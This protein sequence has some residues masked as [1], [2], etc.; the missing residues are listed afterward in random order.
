MN[1]PFELPSELSIYTADSTRQA[2]LAWLQARP[3]QTASPASLQAC[4]VD[5]VDSAGLQ[6]LA[7]LANTLAE[8]GQTLE[9]QQPSAR[10]RAGLRDLGATH[11]FRLNPQE[12]TE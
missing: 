3:E 10:L 8:Q 1:T 7:A 5:E 6:V 11:W 4:Q 9:L 12:M 2:L